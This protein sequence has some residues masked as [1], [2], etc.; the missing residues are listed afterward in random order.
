M[1]AVAALLSGLVVSSTVKW[2]ISAALIISSY[3]FCLSLP[4]AAVVGHRGLSA[5]GPTSA[6]I[7]FAANMLGAWASVAATVVFVYA[8]Y[9]SL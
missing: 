7:V 9:M 3:A 1:L 5:G 6:K 4:L 2:L 8:A